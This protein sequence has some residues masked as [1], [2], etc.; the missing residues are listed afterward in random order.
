MA[1]TLY[2]ATITC[3]YGDCEY[4]LELKTNNLEGR[5]YNT[6]K[7]FLTRHIEKTHNK[8]RKE[9]IK[10]INDYDAEKK[11]AML[12]YSGKCGKELYTLLSLDTT[13][14][15][16]NA[17]DFVKK[18]SGDTKQVLIKHYNTSLENPFITND[19]N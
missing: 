4:E 7:R 13:S 5:E 15:S 19:N 11:T 10:M 18:L 16:F 8:S 14:K 9:A 1:S 2:F 3:P 12:D 17:Y 6:K